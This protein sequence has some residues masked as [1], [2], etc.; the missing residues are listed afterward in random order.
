M[1]LDRNFIRHADP[2]DLGAPHTYPK[3]LQWLLGKIETVIRRRKTKLIQRKP[4][5]LLQNNSTDIIWIKMLKRPKSD[6]KFDKNF[7]MHGKFNSALESVLYQHK[8]YISNYILS[9][10]VDSEEFLPN[11]ELSNDGKHRYWHEVDSCMDKFERSVINLK[12]KNSNKKEEHR[13]KLPQPPSQ[14]N[15]RTF[16]RT[17]FQVP[18]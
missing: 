14:K 16:K 3:I 1:V 10:E 5:A 15:K 9:I 7:S 12:P 6:E 18:I 11:G 17:M 8:G 13:K 4:G 2:S